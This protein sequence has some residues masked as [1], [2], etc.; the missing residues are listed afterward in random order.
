MG[1]VCNKCKHSP[2]IEKH[3]SI[4]IGDE[5]IGEGIIVLFCEKCKCLEITQPSY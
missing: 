1:Y 5:I 4:K 3:L 2:M